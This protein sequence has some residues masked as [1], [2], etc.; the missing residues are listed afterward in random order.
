MINQGVRMLEANLAK[1]RDE[2]TSN[3]VRDHVS[4]QRGYSGR[5][6]HERGTARYDQSSAEEDQSVQFAIALIQGKWKVG[7]L[8]RLR[9]GPARL[10]QLRRTFPL[11]SKKMLTQHLRELERDGLIARRDLSGRVRHVEYFLSDSRGFVVLQLINALTELGSQ[12]A[13][14]FPRSEAVHFSRTTELA[15]RGR[16]SSSLR[17]GNVLLGSR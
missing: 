1:R 4:I 13:S 8:S 12:Y 11:A 5:K 15:M 2:I 3:T 16:E 14:S 7:I 9:V 17:S 6:Q 10:S